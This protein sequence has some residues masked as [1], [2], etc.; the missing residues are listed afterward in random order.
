[1]V[2]TNEYEPAVRAVLNNGMRVI[3][4]GNIVTNQGAGT[5]QDPLYCVA[6]GPGMARASLAFRW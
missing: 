6:A 3:V 2:L 5:N 4:D 1:M